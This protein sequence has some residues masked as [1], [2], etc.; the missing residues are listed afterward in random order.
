MHSLP[1]LLPKLASP[2]YRRFCPLPTIP[3]LCP[4]PS[5]SAPAHREGRSPGPSS[6][7]G[8]LRSGETKAAVSQSGAGRPPQPY[9]RLLMSSPGDSVAPHPS[10]NADSPPSVRGFRAPRVSLQKALTCR[11][12]E[13]KS[14][15][16]EA[17][18]RSAGFQTR[19]LSLPDLQP[20]SP[21]HIADTGCPRGLLSPFPSIRS[22]LP[23]TWAFGLTPGWAEVCGLKLER[24][25][26][27][28]RKL[29]RSTSSPFTVRV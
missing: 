23:L 29:E 12:V 27:N 15:C 14:H 4:C 25:R 5:P 3:C 21:A 7:S 16:S 8:P 22:A 19:Q 11:P 28:Q 2:R 26:R 9:P 1:W 17:A 24:T 6:P 10:P 13:E 18:L 20:Q